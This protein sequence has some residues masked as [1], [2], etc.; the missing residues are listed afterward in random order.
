MCGD[1]REREELSWNVGGF[2]KKAGWDVG[3]M[4]GEASH[5]YICI[6]IPDI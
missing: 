1:T 4:R 3:V 6:Y 2:M 5:T